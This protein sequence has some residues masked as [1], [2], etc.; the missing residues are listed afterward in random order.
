MQS[1]PRVASEPTRLIH[2]KDAR[3]RDHAASVGCHGRFRARARPAYRQSPTPVRE[4]SCLRLI[5]PRRRIL[6]EQSAAA[7]RLLLYAAP[8]FALT[9]VATAQVIFSRQ[10]GLDR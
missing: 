6:R 3:S 7:L 4:G 1:T 5:S 8:R 2:G 10:G 9:T